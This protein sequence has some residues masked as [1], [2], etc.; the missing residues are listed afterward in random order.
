MYIEQVFENLQ[1]WSGEHTIGDHTLNVRGR[2]NRL[3]D[4][5]VEMIYKDRQFTFRGFLSSTKLS[6]SVRQEGYD[7]EKHHIFDLKRNIIENKVSMKKKSKV[8]MIFFT[9]RHID[10]FHIVSNNAIHLND[11]FE[12][13]SIMN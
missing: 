3:E 10:S 11:F 13:Q 9:L 12:Y 6:G 2:W 1:E 8:C 5:R 7:F 4:G